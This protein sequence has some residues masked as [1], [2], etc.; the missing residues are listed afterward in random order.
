MAT[1]QILVKGKVQGVFFRAT[2]RDVAASMGIRGWVRNTDNG[3]VEIMASGEDALLEQLTA[4]C[5]KGPPNAVVREVLVTK[6]PDSPLP[7]FTIRRG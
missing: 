4:W 2:A 7:A 5:R 6:M 3:D 1:I